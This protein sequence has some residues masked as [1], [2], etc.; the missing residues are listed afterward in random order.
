[1]GWKGCAPGDREVPGALRK[2]AEEGSSQPT[3]RDFGSDVR[4]G[5]SAF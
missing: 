3:G 5:A 2:W 4:N 1:M